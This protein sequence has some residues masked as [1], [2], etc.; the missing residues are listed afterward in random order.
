MRV[1]SEGDNISVTKG[2]NR[3]SFWGLPVPLA[4]ALPAHPASMNP[5]AGMSSGLAQ[6]SVSCKTPRDRVLSLD[7]DP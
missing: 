5:Q 1:T 7:L 3:R 2:A 6:Q 4:M